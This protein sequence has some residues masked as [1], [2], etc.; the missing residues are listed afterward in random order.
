MTVV[1]MFKQYKVKEI[2]NKMIIINYRIKLI[3]I[4]N[5]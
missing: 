3:Y 1:I 2:H 4:K 5:K